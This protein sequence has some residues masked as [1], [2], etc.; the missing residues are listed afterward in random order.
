M[1]VRV[2][3]SHE[4]KDEIAERLRLRVEQANDTPAPS[5]ASGQPSRERLQAIL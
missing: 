1:D 2:K 5:P 3:S 4:L